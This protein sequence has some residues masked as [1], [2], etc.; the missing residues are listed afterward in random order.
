[1]NNELVNE[2]NNHRGSTLYKL[3][4]HRITEAVT[5]AV[6]TVM[7]GALNALQG[8]DAED[9]G[10]T[11]RLW[12][13]AVTAAEMDGSLTFPQYRKSGDV[14][15]PDAEPVSFNV[16][17]NVIAGRV[18]RAILVVNGLASGFAEDTWELD[19]VQK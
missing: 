6:N 13:Q 14:I 1:M 11:Q 19:P 9:D 8:L 7:P 2:I 4:N 3:S 17:R 12:E 16:A 15:P 18:A 5:N 10:I